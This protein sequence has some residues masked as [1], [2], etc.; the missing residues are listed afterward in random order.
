[1]DNNSSKPTSNTLYSFR[2]NDG[3]TQDVE[4]KHYRAICTVTKQPKQFHHTY[5]ANMIAHKYNGN[6]DTFVATYVSREGLAQ[7]NKGKRLE[8]IEHK[9]DHLYNQI[10]LLKTERDTLSDVIEQEQTADD[11]VKQL[12][13]PEVGRP[14]PLVPIS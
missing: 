4:L 5:L 1:M 13:E 8:Q 2:T 3:T 10:R 11:V 9:I 6:W 7:K 12:L 14:H